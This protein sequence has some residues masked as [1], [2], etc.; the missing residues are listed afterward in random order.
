MGFENI[1]YVFYI[2][3]R[4]NEESIILTHRRQIVLCPRYLPYAAEDI[5]LARKGVRIIL[6]MFSKKTWLDVNP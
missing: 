6:V 4:D 5:R 2:S 1:V 3:V